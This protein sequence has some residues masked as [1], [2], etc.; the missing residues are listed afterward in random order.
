MVCTCGEN[1]G[2]RIYTHYYFT[3][4]PVT[5]MSWWFL[6]PGYASS[7]SRWVLPQG[8]GGLHYHVASWGLPAHCRS[9][10]LGLLIQVHCYNH[11]ATYGTVFLLHRLNSSSENDTLGLTLPGNSMFTLPSSLSSTLLRVSSCRVLRLNWGLT[12]SL[13]KLTDGKERDTEENGYF[14]GHRKSS[15]M[16]EDAEM[17]EMQDI[18]QGSRPLRRRKRMQDWAQGEGELS[19]R[20]Y[21]LQPTIWGAL[22]QML[23]IRV[24]LLSGQ[25]GQMV[26]SLPHRIQAVPGRKWSW[27]KQ[28][29]TAEADLEGDGNWRKLLTTLPAAG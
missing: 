18:Y 8:S 21:N 4:S 24:I 19:C 2:S 23:L 27:M 6:L 13:R 5:R 22:E 14:E 10:F 1:P 7:F 26:N 20:P 29:C 11:L 15:T 12:V 9:P 3:G 25:N 16:I 17:F 28:L